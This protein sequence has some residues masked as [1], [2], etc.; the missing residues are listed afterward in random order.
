ML[1]PSWPAWRTLTVE[2]FRPDGGGASAIA[3][4]VN[5]E[6]L[7]PQPVQDGWQRY[8]WPLPPAVSAAL[9]RASAELSLIVDGTAFV[10]RAG[11]QRHPVQR[12]AMTRTQ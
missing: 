2:A 3:I 7:P 11:R 5:G 6:T 8:T 10:P 12:S 9:G 4:R 1:P